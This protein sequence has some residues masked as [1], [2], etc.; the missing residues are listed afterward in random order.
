[1]KISRKGSMWVQGKMKNSKIKL[2]LRL[3]WKAHFEK[4]LL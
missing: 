4:S 1:M 3:L 2:I